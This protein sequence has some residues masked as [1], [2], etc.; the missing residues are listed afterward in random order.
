MHALPVMSPPS[1]RFL[2]LYHVSKQWECRLHRSVLNVQMMGGF[3]DH[4]CKMQRIHYM[5]CSTRTAVINTTRAD[6]PQGR[7]LAGINVHPIGICHV[8][9]ANYD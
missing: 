6:A 5:G 4:A 2:P 3:G 1:P 9:Q 8:H 7:A